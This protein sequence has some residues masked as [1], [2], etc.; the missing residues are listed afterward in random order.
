MV[1]LGKCRDNGGLRDFHVKVGSFKPDAWGLY[2][3]HGN[4]WERC[5]G[6][7]TDESDG[8]Y[9]FFGWDSEPKETETD[10]KGPA[11]GSSRILR[12]GGCVQ[13]PSLCGSSA[14]CRVDVGDLGDDVGFR[15]VCPAK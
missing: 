6:R 13:P 2:D 3:M 1:K 7:G 14:R 5:L 8:L 9:R 4:V 10:P 11:V 15:L 12:G